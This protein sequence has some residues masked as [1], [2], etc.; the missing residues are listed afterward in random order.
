M[1]T[2]ANKIRAFKL[3]ILDYVLM[4]NGKIEHYM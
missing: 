3:F 2:K 1:N 4:V